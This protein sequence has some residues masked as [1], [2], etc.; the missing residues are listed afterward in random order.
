MLR[1]PT[2]VSAAVTQSCI[3]PPDLSTPDTAMHEVDLKP[4]VDLDAMVREPVDSTSSKRPSGEIVSGAANR[5]PAF[6]MRPIPE[7]I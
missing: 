7:R 1:N 2:A 3:A 5:A 4:F 6:E